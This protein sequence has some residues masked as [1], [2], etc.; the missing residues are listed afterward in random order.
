MVEDFGSGVAV[1]LALTKAGGLLLRVAPPE[2]ATHVANRRRDKCKRISRCAT[3]A[4]T[5][6]TLLPFELPGVCRKKL[7]VDL[8][9]G[10]Q[11]SDPVLLVRRQA[12]RKLGLCARSADRRPRL[13]T[14]KSFSVVRIA[15][16]SSATALSPASVDVD[17]LHSRCHVVC[18]ARHADTESNDC[19]DQKIRSV[20][21]NH[22]NKA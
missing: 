19:G 10:N 6:D 20:H 8:D 14:A 15:P 13:Q 4:M 11:S 16:R 22:R 1:M 12:E 17:F 2:A 18:G 21:S 7:T 5:D 3:A 9:S